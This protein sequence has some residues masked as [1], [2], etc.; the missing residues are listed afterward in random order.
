MRGSDSCDMTTS[1]RL[2]HGAANV[3]RLGGLGRWAA[4]TAKRLDEFA[5]RFLVHVG[6]GDIGEVR[7]R[8]ARDVVAVDRF[9]SACPA[10][11]LGV[12]W[13]FGHRDNVLIVPVNERRRRNSI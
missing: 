13:Q 4:A 10:G 2:D 11:E 8:P 7:I 1:C 6:N 3:S 9:Y 12:D 5:E